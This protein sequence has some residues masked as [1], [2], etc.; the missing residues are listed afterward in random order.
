MSSNGDRR[1][2]KL[3]HPVRDE[4]EERTVEELRFRAGRFADLKGLRFQF[5]T[6]T[7]P[8]DFD[9]LMT[10]AS[11]LSGETS[12]VIGKLEGEDLAEVGR[13]ALD[14]YLSFLATGA[15]G[16]QSSPEG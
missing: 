16:S 6:E 2:V 5:G 14:F 7:V 8:V 13:L 11:R 9:D 15:T 12:H 10:I 3:R 1:L 4:A